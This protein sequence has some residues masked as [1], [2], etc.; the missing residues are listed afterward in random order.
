MGVDCKEMNVDGCLPVEAEGVLISH[1]VEHN[2]P[3]QQ[4]LEMILTSM[5][6]LDLL[7][8]YSAT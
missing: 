3:Y 4:V 8:F 7:F 5:V 1:T 2:G 6:P